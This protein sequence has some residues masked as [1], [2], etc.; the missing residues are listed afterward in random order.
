MGSTDY[1]LS[2]R[3]DNDVGKEHLSSEFVGVLYREDTFK[4]CPR[5]KV[6]R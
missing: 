3:N 5:G 1:G 6:T 2:K 4:K